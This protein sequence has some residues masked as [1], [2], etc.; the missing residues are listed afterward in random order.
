MPDGTKF[1]AFKPMEFITYDKRADRCLA[2]T[3]EKEAML[4]EL[5]VYCGERFTN[6]DV[7]RYTKKIFEK[8]GIISLRSRGGS[9]FV[10]AKYDSL[11][12]NMM[13]AFLEID[14]K[15]DF[16]MIE[17]ADLE[18]SKE[19]IKNNFESDLQEKMKFMK[20]KIDKVK[21]D[22]DKLS[23]TVYKNLIEEIATWSK[24]IEMYSELTE[25][26]LDD[27]KQLVKESVVLV[28]NFM[29]SGS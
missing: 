24:D 2:E 11:I 15:G 14:P 21:T 27:A 28:T 13:K 3:P 1:K 19:S 16:T 22:G 29:Q 5:M 10:P 8:C 17:I 12:I 20:E 7:T 18:Y 25:Y 9:Y 26:T 6:A 4:H 23:R